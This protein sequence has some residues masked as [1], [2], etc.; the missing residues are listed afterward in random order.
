MKPEAADL[1]EKAKRSLD[2]AR[3]L[4]ARGDYDFSVS[5]LY[6][7][8]FYVAEALLLTKG[9]SFS[10]HSAV[11]SALH[12][13][14]VKPGLLPKEMHQLIHETFDR[15][16]EADYEAGVQIAREEVDSLISRAEKFLKNAMPL[17]A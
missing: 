11:L 5:R 2:V 15:R 6:Y 3:E 4:Q 9:M 12:E 7:A 8:L 10:S 17:L 1:V 16:Q 13:Q 14:F